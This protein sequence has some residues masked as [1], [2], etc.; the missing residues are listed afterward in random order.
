MTWTQLSDDWMDHPKI[1]MVSELA[2][3]LWV[4]SIT[5]CNKHLTDGFVPRAALRKLTAS[6]TP[7][8]LAEELVG[9]IPPGYSAGLWVACDGGWMV[10]H[11]LEHGNPSR[12]KVTERRRA[13]AERQ[14]Q[15]RARRVSHGPEDCESRHVSQRD[16][17]SDDQRD[18]TCDSHGDQTSDSPRARPGGDG[19]GDLDLGSALTPEGAQG[20]PQ[21]KRSRKKPEIPLPDD[22]GPIASHYEKGQKLGMSRSD[23]DAE[24]ERFKIKAR[25]RQYVYADWNLAF[26]SWLISPLQQQARRPVPSRQPSLLTQTSG[27]AP[28][29]P[30][31]EFG[32]KP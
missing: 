21:I 2:A 14:S 28:C 23:V 11:F 6:K 26:H 16:S 19:N 7:D 8:K 30:L 4:K 18:G 22:W 9:A 1:L 32:D 12:E 25:L 31:L 20:G 5:Y 10:H 15:S 24:V 17:H 3:F 27:A 29:K 13:A